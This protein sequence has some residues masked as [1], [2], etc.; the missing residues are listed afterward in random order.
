ML[1]CPLWP[2]WGC[3]LLPLIVCQIRDVDLGVVGGEEESLID[4]VALVAPLNPLRPLITKRLGY[5]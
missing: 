2:A 3:P 4:P 1:F 5:I